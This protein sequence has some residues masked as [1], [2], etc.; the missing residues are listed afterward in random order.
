MALL[1]EASLVLAPTGLAAAGAASAAAWYFR[2]AALRGN[3][4]LQE[5]LARVK[6]RD[7][8]VLHLATVRLPALAASPAPA[9]PTHAG[10]LLHPQLGATP[11]GMALQGLMKQTATLVGDVQHRAEAAA[12]DQ[13]RDL[14]QP[15][16]AMVNRQQSAMV[17]VLGT[18]ADEGVLAHAF[19]VDHMGTLLAQR[20]DII[21]VLL[22]EDVASEHPDLPLMSVLAGAQS[23]VKDYLRVQIPTGRQ[24]IVR[25]RVAGPV[26]VALGELA[27]NGA[28]HSTPKTPVAVQVMEVEGGL[29]VVIDSIGPMLRKDE[30]QRAAALLPGQSRPRLTG[31]GGRLGFAAVGVLARQHG[32]QVWLDPN[33]G[34]GVRAVL[35]LPGHLLVR[36]PVADEPEQHGSAVDGVGAGAVRAEAGQ[37]LA[38][39]SRAVRAA[40]HA[41]HQPGS[42]AARP[43]AQG[44]GWAPAGREVR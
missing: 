39:F 36:P 2:R 28:R 16:V 35:H 41:P 29:C 5:G 31:L 17:Q 10:P 20:M 1:Q 3:H 43:G 11:F 4:A 19:A 14:L 40:G 38:D 15:L 9:D 21:R 30:Y 32:F 34:G 8:E 12:H 6:S 42:P 33:W 37:R 13:I 7:D 25:G 18:I 27:E 44:G 22:G 23:R 26:A 24:D